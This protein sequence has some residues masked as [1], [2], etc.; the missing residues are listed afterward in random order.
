MDDPVDFEPDWPLC[1][2]HTGKVHAVVEN[3]RTGV[4]PDSRPE[5]MKVEK[6]AAEKRR[7]Q[8]RNRQ[9]GVDPSWVYYARINDQIKIGY[10][11]DVKK[12]MR[13][14][15]PGTTV[16]AVEPGDEALEKARHR[17]FAHSLSDGREWFRESTPLMEW[18]EKLRKAYGDTSDM[19]HV[20]RKHS[21]DEV[22]PSSKGFWRI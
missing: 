9:R 18:I 15:P 19:S 5:P 8:T 7:T 6:E 2:S 10:A 14:Y 3:I 22:K 4:A 20:Y 16:L 1:Y 17:E 13:A 21:R 11:A 12:R